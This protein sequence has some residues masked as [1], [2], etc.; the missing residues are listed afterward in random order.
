MSKHEQLVGEEATFALRDLRK[1]QLGRHV[2]TS[3]GRGAYEQYLNPR[4][5][6][7][8]HPLDPNAESSPRPSN[9]VDQ[10]F[11]QAQQFHDLA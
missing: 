1:N 2:Q 9:Y 10:I 5:E 11:F 3:R 6:Q 8:T 4:I 7:P